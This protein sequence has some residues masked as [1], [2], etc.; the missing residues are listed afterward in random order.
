MRSKTLSEESEFILVVALLIGNLTMVV[1]YLFEN[2]LVF[3][4][5]KENPCLK[6]RRK[7][8]G[9][10]EGREYQMDDVIK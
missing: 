10:E 9:R 7:R 8:E 2:L 1:M 3:L 5:G 4:W 6:K